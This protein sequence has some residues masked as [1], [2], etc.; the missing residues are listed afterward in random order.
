VLG[1]FCTAIGFILHGDEDEIYLVFVTFAAVAAHCFPACFVVRRLDVIKVNGGAT[2]P[3]SDWIVA[4]NLLTLPASAL[5]QLLPGV[6]GFLLV[7]I[8]VTLH[9]ISLTCLGAQY[10]LLLLQLSL[11]CSE[12]LSFYDEKEEDEES[13]FLYSQ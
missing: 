7:S 12:H 4:L 10:R 13:S 9:R 6:T 2:S 5:P 8:L 11:G 1:F 3:V